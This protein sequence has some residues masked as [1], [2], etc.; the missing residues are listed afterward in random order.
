M[1]VSCLY[2]IIIIKI[3]CISDDVI[4]LDSSAVQRER[5]QAAA[6]AAHVPMQQLNNAAAAAI[7][8]HKQPVMMN[9]SPLTDGDSELDTAAR[10]AVESNCV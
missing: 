10:G 3:D 7:V 1:I 6:A 8:M 5:E 9:G 4:A 2:E